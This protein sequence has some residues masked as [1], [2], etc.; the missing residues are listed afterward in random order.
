MTS[1]EGEALRME[2][3]EWRAVGDML[4]RLVTEN[5]NNSSKRS[6]D[7]PKRVAATP[8][9]PPESDVAVMEGEQP[10]V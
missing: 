4:W 5:D 10:R 8:P 6:H 2:E 1:H 9:E 3:E 7:S